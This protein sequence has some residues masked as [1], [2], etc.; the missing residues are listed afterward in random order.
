MFGEMAEYRIKI[1]ITAE[2]KKPQSD[3]MWIYDVFISDILAHSI[4]NS[5]KGVFKRS[6]CTIRSS[7]GSSGSSMMP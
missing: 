6:A 5:T 3:C 4:K 2:G 1:S 7:S